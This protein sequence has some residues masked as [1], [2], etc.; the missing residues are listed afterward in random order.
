VELMREIET[1][2][3]VLEALPEGA[4]RRGA[5]QRLSQLQQQLALQMER[6][7]AG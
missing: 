6:L 2:R 1:Q 7:R 3:H 5:Q 4:T